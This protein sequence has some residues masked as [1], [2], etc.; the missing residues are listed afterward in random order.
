M[1]K[2]KEI[3]RNLP[4]NIRTALIISDGWLV[5]SSV[6]AILNGEEVKDYDIIVP[7]KNWDIAILSLKN[8]PFELN[9]FGGFKFKIPSTKEGKFDYLDIWPQDVDTFMKVAPKCPYLF[10]LQRQKLYKTDE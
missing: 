5:G 10:N 7:Y 9:T 1:S 8:Y 2:I 3:Y 6:V 4:V